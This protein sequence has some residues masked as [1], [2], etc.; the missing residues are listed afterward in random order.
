MK[1]KV[2]VLLCALFLSA[3]PGWA[4]QTWN[5]T[6][7]MSA[8]L[9]SK[10]T[11]TVTTTK[12][13]GEEMPDYNGN[14]PGAALWINV[15]SKIFSIIIEPGVTSIGNAAFFYCNNLASV[16]L[17]DSLTRIGSQ[18]FYGCSSLPSITIPVGVTSIEGKDYTGA[19]YGCS[20]LTSVTIHAPSISGGV[21]SGSSINSVT[22]GHTVKHIGD[23]AFYYCRNLISVTIPNS[24]EIIDN[25][26]FY[27]CSSLI[28]A[29]IGDSVT[30]IGQNAFSN[31]SL[32]SI[33]IPYS[34]TSIGTTPFAYCNSLAT[35]TVR[36]SSINNA[37][38]GLGITSLILGDSV[39]TLGVNAFSNCGKLASITFGNGLE[40]IGSNAFSNC[41]SLK[42][43][44]IPDPV[45]TIGASAF[46][47]CDHLAS[48]TIPSSVI[49]IGAE[50]FSG[51][52]E[53]ME[54]TVRWATPLAVA[55]NT[56]ESVNLSAATL[57]VPAGTEALYQAAPV[58]KNFSIVADP[59]P[60]SNEK[61]LQSTLQ[62]YAA[63]GSLHINTPAPCTLYIYTSAGALVSHQAISAGETTLPLPHGLYIIKAGKET[64]K[65]VIR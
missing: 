44:V 27:G 15:R 22:F 16:T 53:L 21:F 64:R 1:T 26:A 49:E 65:V 36:S 57:Y 45:K 46:R 12:E 62:V 5:L 13:G 35:V 25:G 60:V 11:L 23:G 7:T 48:V 24:V 8:A 20:G 2:T 39:K 3:V 28:S 61:V 37:F 14:S 18:A 58:W 17:P 54:V 10:G 59:I 9:D 38:S 6:T 19:F 47:S 51:C 52:K 40:T 33:E 30:T 50:A 32:T 55:A 56:F 42:S 4:Q 31:T 34:V 41:D 29:V 43:V 63:A